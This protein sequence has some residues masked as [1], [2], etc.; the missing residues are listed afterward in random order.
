MYIAFVIE[1][2]K[3]GFVNGSTSAKTGI[4]CVVYKYAGKAHLG[5]DYWERNWQ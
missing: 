5:K 2:E 3:I 1:S 4:F